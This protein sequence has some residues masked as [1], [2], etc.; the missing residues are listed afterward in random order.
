LFLWCPIDYPSR[1]DLKIIDRAAG[2]IVPRLYQQRQK[3][4]PRQ[5]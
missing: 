2:K 1:I 4:L 3:P 5:H